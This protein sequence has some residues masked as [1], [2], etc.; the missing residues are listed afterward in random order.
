MSYRK[1]GE[2][3]ERKKHVKRSHWKNKKCALYMRTSGPSWYPSTTELIADEKCVDCSYLPDNSTAAFSISFTC[4]NI[5]QTIDLCYQISGVSLHLPT[6]VYQFKQGV[7]D[8]FL[9]LEFS[10]ILR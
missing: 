9:K 4:S 2:K 7:A 5:Q 1:E 3:K 8:I 10:I 6:V